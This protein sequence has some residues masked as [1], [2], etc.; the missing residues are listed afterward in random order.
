[1]SSSPPFFIT[2]R[3]VFF[4]VL[5]ELLPPDILS[6]QAGVF[7]ELQHPNKGSASDQDNDGTR[8]TLKVHLGLFSA[9]RLVERD[10]FNGLR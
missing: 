3:F 10:V 5:S 4:A 6:A 7:N 8:W 1:M 9:Y 2:C